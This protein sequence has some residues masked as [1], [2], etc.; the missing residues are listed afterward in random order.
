MELSAR[1]V[2]TVLSLGAGVQSSTLALMAAHGEVTPMPDIAIFAD[3]GWEPKAVYD[4]LAWL[5]TKLPFPVS[6]V[7]SGTLRNDQITAR[8][9]AKKDD[10][11]GRWASLPYFTR[12]AG[13]AREGIMRR[14]CTS[15]YKIQPIEHFIRHELMRLRPRQRAPKA[16]TI[17][18]W[19]G[20]SLD[21]IT[22]CKKEFVEPWRRN[23]YPLIEKRMTRGHCLEWMS[24]NG[25][26][27]P[28]RSACLGCPFHSDE[29]WQ[30]IKDGPAYEWADVVEFDA[31]IRHAGGMRGDTFLHRSCKPI[32]EIE[33][34][35]VAASGQYSML[36][37]CEGMC[38][39]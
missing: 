11:G 17:E 5:E 33:F 18:Q 36:D 8:V 30:R 28:P 13:S 31:A 38:G 25:Y 22:R 6:T 39:V 4:W 19:Y 15:E 27:Q 14:Q 16:L 35:T 37:E 2:I 23:R 10:N 29:E 12:E 21:E 3:T 1:A 20:I 26:P 34:N 9:R 32:A 7:G 24:R